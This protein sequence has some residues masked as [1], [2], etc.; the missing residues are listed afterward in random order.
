MRRC[1]EAVECVG[2][3]GHVPKASQ[4]LV[5]DGTPDGVHTDG[6]SESISVRIVMLVLGGLGLG[7]VSV[8]Q[9]GLQSRGEVLLGWGPFDG[10]RLLSLKTRSKG[11]GLVSLHSSWQD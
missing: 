4:E 7:A 5:D 8:L 2:W 11:A 6:L 10:V 9:T 1:V 3:R